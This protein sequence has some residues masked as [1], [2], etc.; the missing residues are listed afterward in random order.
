MLFWREG[1]VREGEIDVGEAEGRERVSQR[2]EIDYTNRVVW[3]SGHGSEEL[4]DEE[5]GEEEGADVIGGELRFYT[6]VGKGTRGEVHYSGVV[7]EEM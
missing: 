6:F 1:G 5:I 3:R 4:G 2:R 7:D